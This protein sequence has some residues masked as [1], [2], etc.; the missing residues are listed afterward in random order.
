MCS[1]VDVWVGGFVH[2]FM[3]MRVYALAIR[4]VYVFLSAFL[5]AE[6]S[7]CAFGFSPLP[8]KKDAH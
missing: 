3:C 7:V 1:R 4:C 2:I 6:H 8:K 5:S